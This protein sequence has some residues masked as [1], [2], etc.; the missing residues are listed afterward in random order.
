MLSHAA[1]AAQRPGRHKDRLV[2][3]LGNVFAMRRAPLLSGRAP[4][5]NLPINSRV[6]CTGSRPSFLPAA[7]A[8]VQPVTHTPVE[9]D[10]VAIIGVIW[11]AKDSTNPYPLR[12]AARGFWNP[13]AARNTCP[14]WGTDGVRTRR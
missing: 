4:W 5:F 1:F 6:S 2:I 11:L 8:D 7:S 9:A 14:L 10:G 13:P 12:R 3:V